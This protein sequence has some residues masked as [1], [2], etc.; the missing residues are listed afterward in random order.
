MVD[1]VPRGSTYERERLAEFGIDTT[2]L[3]PGS[4]VFASICIVCDVLPPEEEMV[5]GA[6]YFVRETEV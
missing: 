6:L 2:I 4:G 3:E 5:E 1:V